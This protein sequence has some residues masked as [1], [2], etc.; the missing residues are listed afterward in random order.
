MRPYSSRPTLSLSVIKLKVQEKTYKLF[1]FGFGLLANKHELRGR[2]G[3]AEAGK[4]FYGGSNPPVTAVFHMA[5]NHSF[6]HSFRAVFLHCLLFCTYGHKKSSL[7]G[8][9]YEQAIVIVLIVNQSFFF[10]LK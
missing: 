2:V 1:A 9:M 8:S 10:N 4:P 3:E 6:I 7:A 5:S